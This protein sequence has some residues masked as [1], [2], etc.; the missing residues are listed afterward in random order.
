MALVLQMKCARK[1]PTGAIFVGSIE[2]G[3]VSIYNNIQ[4]HFPDDLDTD[5]V[6]NEMYDVVVTRRPKPVAPAKSKA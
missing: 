1:E 2:S 3:K 6:E 5:I 4:I